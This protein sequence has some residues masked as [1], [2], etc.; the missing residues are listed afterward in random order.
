MC[1][2]SSPEPSPAQPGPA[3]PR[4]LASPPR[5][6]KPS[7]AWRE[8]LPDLGGELADVSLYLTA[9]EEVNGVD[10]ASEVER[11]IEENARRTPPVSR[12]PSRSV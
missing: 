2:R 6:A 12:S 7:P 8:G 5:P 4:Q 1:A 3:R 11:K 10:L 9:R